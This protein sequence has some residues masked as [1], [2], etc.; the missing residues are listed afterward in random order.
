VPDARVLGELDEL[1]EEFLAA[2][3]SRMRLAAKMNCTGRS[4]SS[5]SFVTRSVSRRISEARL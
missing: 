5:R 3:V 1:L 4:M 2:L